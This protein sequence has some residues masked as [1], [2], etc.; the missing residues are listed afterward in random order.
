[1]HLD[2]C[3]AGAGLWG[4]DDLVRKYD[5]VSFAGKVAEFVC[6][7]LREKVNWGHPRRRGSGHVRDRLG[8]RRGRG[9]RWRPRAGHD[10]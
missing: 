9:G 8:E 4:N 10:A 2:V 3:A 1:M 7:N 5:H 6:E